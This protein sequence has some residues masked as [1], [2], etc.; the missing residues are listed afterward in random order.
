VVQSLAS[1][2]LQPNLYTAT[3]DALLVLTGL[4]LL[5]GCGGSGRSSAHG[6]WAAASAPVACCR[7]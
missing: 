5:F 2:G 7:G 1:T 6:G 4:L 3:G